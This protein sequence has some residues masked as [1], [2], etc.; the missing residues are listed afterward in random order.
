MAP[1]LELLPSFRITE[2]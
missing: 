2:P 1:P